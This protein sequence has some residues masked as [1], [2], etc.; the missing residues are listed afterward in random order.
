MTEY[1]QAK[2]IPLVTV[3]L[4]S[5]ATTPHAQLFCNHLRT[6]AENYLREYFKDREKN[7][8]IGLYENLLGR[9][10]TLNSYCC[11]CDKPLGDEGAFFSTFC[12]SS[13]CSFQGEEFLRAHRKTN[14]AAYFFL[15]VLKK[16][17]I[18]EPLKFS[19]QALIL[20]ETPDQIASFERHRNLK[21]AHF[22]YYNNDREDW[23]DVLYRPDMLVV[24]F[25]F[26]KD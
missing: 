8:L 17:E 24:V 10:K 25:F 11:F 1:R 6:I 16:E 21:G 14:Q 22:L 2:N 13:L 19:H 20:H 18:F 23:M 15:I 5:G 7:V 12:S 3:V 9:I 26:F 4:S